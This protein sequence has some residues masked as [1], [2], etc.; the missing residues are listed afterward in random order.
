MPDAGDRALKERFAC[1][2]RAWWLPVSGAVFG[3]IGRAWRSG[4][5]RLSAVIHTDRMPG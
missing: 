5:Q 4:N 3:A 1:E 2:G